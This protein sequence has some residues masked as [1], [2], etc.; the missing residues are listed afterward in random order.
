VA[1]RHLRTLVWKISSRKQ[2]DV[3]FLWR[4]SEA[5]ETSV[6]PRLQCLSNHVLGAVHHHPYCLASEAMI[7]TTHLQIKP[8]CVLLIKLPFICKFSYIWKIWWIYI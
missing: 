7:Q 3:C 1:S 8:M 5:E 4:D 2:R 6:L